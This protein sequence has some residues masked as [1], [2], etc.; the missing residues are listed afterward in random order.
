MGEG[1]SKDAK[2]A[3]DLGVLREATGGDRDLMEELAE[4]YVSDA[5]LQ[6]RALDDAMDNRDM[7]RI[8]RIGRTLRAASESVGAAAA[9]EAFARLEA[10]ARAGSL[11]AVRE[12]T[13]AVRDEFV[14]VKRVLADLR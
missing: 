13:E 10:G 8:R 14:R 6:I 3:V 1:S 9:A 7:D 4:L 5:D 12:A 11:E 2:P